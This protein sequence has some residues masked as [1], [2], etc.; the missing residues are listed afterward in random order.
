[1]Y[2]C[3]MKRIKIAIFA[4]GN[5][6]NALNLIEYFRDHAQIEVAV[7]VSNNPNAPVLEKVKP[8]AV[9]TL[10][11]SNEQFETGV[12]LVDALKKQEI[13]WIILAG[14]LRK[15]PQL[16]LN[17]F[18]NRI[19]NVHPSLL[20]KFGGKGMYG[21]HVHR[22]VV[23]AKEPVSGI[24]IHLVNENFDEGKILAQFSTPL[25]LDKTAESVAT[26]IHVLEQKHFPY[27]VEQTILNQIS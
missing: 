20:P 22:A 10:L 24:T 8:F 1:M 27:I 5:G 9:E 7:V 12:E 4:S 2:F 17:N 25:G 18:P 14:F 23:E 16:I 13:E 15:I 3:T 19:I 21:M 11:F 26:K 6:S